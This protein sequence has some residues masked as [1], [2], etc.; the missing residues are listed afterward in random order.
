MFAAFC[1]KYPSISPLIVFK[2]LEYARSY[3]AVFDALE[4]YDG[5]LPIVWD[6]NSQKWL[7]EVLQEHE[8]LHSK[9]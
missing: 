9:D 2:T 1:K 7:P 6:H 4:D 8:F 5:E 3:G